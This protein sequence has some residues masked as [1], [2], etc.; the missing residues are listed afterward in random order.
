VTA[1]PDVPH[2]DKVAYGAYMATGLGHCMDCHTPLD[3]GRNDMTRLGAGGNEF[4]MPSGGVLTSANLTPANKIGIA[5]WTDAQLVT[6]LRTGV[7]P[8]GSH[9]VPLMAFGWYK[10]V[11]DEDYAALVAYLRTLKPVQ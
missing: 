4:G 11:D 7:R 3:K 6:A 8:N 10:T 2:D 9:I 1:V 5:G